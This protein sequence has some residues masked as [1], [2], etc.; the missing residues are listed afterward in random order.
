MR[1]RLIKRIS[2]CQQEA[3]CEKS[4]LMFKNF[5][6]FIGKQL[7]QCLFLNKFQKGDWCFEFCEEFLGTPFQV[8]L[9]PVQAPLVAASE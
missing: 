4:V 1:E 9:T 8:F 5:A 6:K 7:C 2:S 3:F